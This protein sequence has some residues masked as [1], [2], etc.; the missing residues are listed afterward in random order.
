MNNLAE[1]N[2]ESLKLNR[3]NIVV[4]DDLK[5]LGLA[6]M[7][8]GSSL[9]IMFQKRTESVRIS[10]VTDSELYK[11]SK[12]KTKF[13]SLVKDEFK[14]LGFDGGFRETQRYETEIY[15]RVIQNE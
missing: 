3:E 5:M 14:I 7:L 4:A 1:R 12:K 11:F 10:E 8:V 2:A 15:A 6:K 13:Y 9:I